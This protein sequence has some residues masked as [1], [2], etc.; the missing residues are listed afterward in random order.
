[1]HV[2]ACIP[3]RPLDG[4]TKNW[5]SVAAGQALACARRVEAHE[6]DPGAASASIDVTTIAREVGVSRQNRLSLP[7]SAHRRPACMQ[8]C[9]SS[10]SMSPWSLRP[11]GA[12]VEWAAATPARSGASCRAGL[13]ALV[14]AGRLWFMAELRKETAAER[15]AGA[16][17]APVYDV[18]KRTQRP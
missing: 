1:M 6:R 7:E 13:Y 14:T 2:G 10:T 3:F 8:A 12:E 4:I 16:A 17:A 11:C 5:R 9:G 15:W 18:E